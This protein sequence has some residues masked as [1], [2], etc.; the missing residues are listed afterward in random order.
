MK[1]LFFATVAKLL[2]LQPGGGVGFILFGVVISL[3]TLSAFE[4][5]RHP[6]GF[7]CHLFLYFTG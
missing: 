5:N 1:S 4:S 6:G 3:L 7:L 2:K